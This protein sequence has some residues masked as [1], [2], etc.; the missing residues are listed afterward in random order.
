MKRAGIFLLMIVI[1]TVHTACQK[2][3][4]TNPENT[5][6]EN[7]AAE[8]GESQTGKEGEKETKKEKKLSE[9]EAR[10]RALKVY[11]QMYHQV[12]EENPESSIPIIETAEDLRRVALSEVFD[13]S[14]GHGAHYYHLREKFPGEYAAFR[15][16]R[17]EGGTDLLL[18]VNLQ[19]GQ[20]FD[21][22]G[23][24]GVTELPERELV[25]FNPYIFDM[26]GTSAFLLSR[27]RE[28]GV[29]ESEEGYITGFDAWMLYEYESE[30]D[31]GEIPE[32]ISRVE[33]LREPELTMVGIYDFDLVTYE[34]VSY[35]EGTPI[36]HDPL[37]DYPEKD[38]G[39]ENAAEELFAILQHLYEIPKTAKLEDFDF[40][41]EKRFFDQADFDGYEVAVKSDRGGFGEKI[42]ALDPL[43]TKVYLLPEG[44]ENIILIY[45]NQMK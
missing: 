26:S 41:V 39:E 6:T 1:L 29:I 30:N 21:D 44:E 16:E 38:I 3:E 34:I 5:Q 18:Y 2:Q 11:Q 12:T 4:G 19:T 7:G 36:Y 35:P 32:G 28:A 40:R 43:G 42:Y 23:F 14:S 22:Y 37:S 9:N 31:L 20:V 45:G 27:L 25:V 33:I 8:R 15:Y 17:P 13:E 24:A 10:D